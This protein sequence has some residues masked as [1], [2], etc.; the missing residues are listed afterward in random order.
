MII[1]K[2]Y[3][4]LPIKFQCGSPTMESYTVFLQKKKRLSLKNEIQ[5][6]NSMNRGQPDFGE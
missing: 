1:S 2:G 3:E 4:L 5:Q 6:R